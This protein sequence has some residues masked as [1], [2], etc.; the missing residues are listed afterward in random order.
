MKIY[1]AILA[2]CAIPSS[3][4]FVVQAPAFKASTSLYSAPS[5]IGVMN[6]NTEPKTTTSPALSANSPTW[7]ERM[8][9]EQSNGVL[10]SAKE[11]WDASS[12]I[13]IQGGSLRTCSFD[14]S[15]N[16]VQVLLKTE[17]RP[18]TS[19]VELWQGPD[20]TP[21]QINVYIEDGSYRPF[22]AVIET[23]GGSNAVCI[24]NT[25][26][27]EFPLAACVDGESATSP[28]EQLGENA[29]RILQG[30]AVHTTPFSANVQSVQILLKTDGRP[31]NARIELLQGPN[32]NKQVMEVYVEDGQ[33]RPFYAVIETPGTGN[34]VRI[35]NTST[36][37]YPLNTSIEPYI[38]DDTIV[39]EA[40]PQGMVWSN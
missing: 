18:L 7:K 4:A 17:G 12:P 30:G 11:I 2:I 28:I 38:I 22:R 40:T 34:V 31:M 14:E 27:M 23:P 39:A 9:A 5:Y 16:R 33:T 15:V 20:N 24:R 21:Q 25:G 26:N 19:N 29:S 35:V 8:G 10:K 32:N 3:S 37:E 13:T 1:G 6:E 36:V